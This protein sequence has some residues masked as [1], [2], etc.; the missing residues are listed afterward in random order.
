MQVVFAEQAH[1]F[2]VV[3]HAVSGF[4][5][6]FEHYIEGRQYADYSGPYEVTPMITS[7][8]LETNDLHMRD[9]VRIFTI[10]TRE[11]AN[12]SGGVT[13]IVGG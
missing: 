4:Q 13:F 3:F 10:P 8:R 2:P 11:E 5:I 12:P 1:A 9:D 6:A 7:Q